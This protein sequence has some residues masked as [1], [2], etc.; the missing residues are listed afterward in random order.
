MLQRKVFPIWL[1]MYSLQHCS[2]PSPTHCTYCSQIN[3]SK[4]QSFSGHTSVQKP[5]RLP[6][7]YETNFIPLSLMFKVL[8]NL[9]RLKLT[10]ITFPISSQT[11]SL[12]AFVSAALFKKGLFSFISLLV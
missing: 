5:Q 4:G 3:C 7:I 1:L 6:V 10:L 2:I 11:E 9:V 8:H 12:Q